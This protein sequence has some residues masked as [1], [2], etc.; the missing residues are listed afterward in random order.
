[1]LIEWFTKI[2]RM[3]IFGREGFGAWAGEMKNVYMDGTF[4]ITP[5]H[6]SQLCDSGSVTLYF[7]FL[8][9]IIRRGNWVLPVL[10]CLV[11]WK[12][13]ATYTRL[14]R[15][16]KNF[17]PAFYPESVSMDFE[18]GAIGKRNFGVKF[19]GLHLRCSQISLQTPLICLFHLVRNMKKVSEL[20][21][22]Q[23]FKS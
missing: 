17:W 20:G 19:Y 10:Y 1:M 14:F 13:A 23:V 8:K 2:F 21:L 11:T 5:T 7:R 4:S 18:I 16:I 12:A 6:F 22:T 9:S 3:L 15:S